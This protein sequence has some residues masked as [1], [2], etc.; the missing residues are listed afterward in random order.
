MTI[1]FYSFQYVTDPESA[2][3]RKIAKQQ[4]K[5]VAKKRKMETM[6]GKRGIRKKVKKDIDLEVT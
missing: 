3:K 5:K 4:K 6:K 1:N 2:A